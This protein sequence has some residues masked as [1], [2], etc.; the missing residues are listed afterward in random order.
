MRDLYNY[1]KIG[2]W[3]MEGAYFK[4]GNFYTNKLYELEFI[5]TLEAHDIFC[6]QETH[7]GPNDIPSQHMK[8]YSSIP[9]CRGKSAN[10]RYFGGMLLLIKKNIRQGV[11]VSSTDDPD[12][13]GI[14]LKKDFFNLPEDT[15]VWFTYAS[16]I[17][18]PYTKRREDVLTKLETYMA[19]H[20]KHQIIMGD[21]NGR[22]ATETDYI[23]EEYDAHSPLQDISHYQLDSPLNRNNMDSQP[24]DCRGKRILSVCKNLQV[25]ILNGRTAGDRWCC[26]Q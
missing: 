17:S 16:P 23:H 7:C 19:A 3:N 21:L 8:N 11:K 2:S 12:I 6:I 15:Y 5:N 13:L 14:T 10:N 4:T 20:G 18:S 25:R 1:V 24:V 9:H 22:T 26:T